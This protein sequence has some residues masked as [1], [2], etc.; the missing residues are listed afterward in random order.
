[1]ISLEHHETRSV[2][3]HLHE[4]RN[5]IFIALGTFIVGSVV[6]HIFHEKIIAFLL[7]PIGQQHLIF[8][9]PLEPLIF[10]FKIDFI[11]GFVIA[12]PVIIWCLFSYITPALPKKIS[13]VI[14]LFYT[15]STFLLFLGLFYAFFVTIPLSLKFLSSI[16]IP[17][18]VN[19]FSVEKYISF[20]I[21]QALIIMTIFQV[22]ILIIGGVY[23]GILKTKLFANKRRYIYMGLLIALSI[24]TPTTDIFSL[25]IIFIPCI[26]IFEMSLFGGKFVE[27]FKR[28]KSGE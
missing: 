18:I 12:F 27:Y 2:V 9:S 14:I 16:T 17:G 24:I 13:S 5:K 20:F 22:P 26:L 19:S 8:L 4:L 15:T 6:A 21:T 23:I 7:Q 10:I 28:K 11:T 3:E 1:M 25:A